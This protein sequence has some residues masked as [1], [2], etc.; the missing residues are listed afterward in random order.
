MIFR[1]F[2]L[3]ALALC[4]WLS[5]GMATAQVEMSVA[6]ARAAGMAQASLA[7]QDAWAVFNNPAAY[8]SLTNV[9]FGLY[10]EN[11]FLLKETGYA[12]LTVTTP[13][14]AGNIGFGV[15]HFGY[16]YFQSDRFSLGYAQTLFR[17]LALGV[18]IDY[19]SIRQAE[20]YGNYNALT[21]DVGILARPTDKLFIGSY[22][23]NPLNISSFEDKDLKLPVSLR[24]GV[25]Y[26]FSDALLLSLETGKTINGHSPLL[27][28][29]I[30][31][32]IRKQFALRA[33]IAAKPVEYSCGFGYNKTFGK[34]HNLKCDLAFA[35]HQILGSSPKISIN[36]AF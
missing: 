29:G 12:A 3:P 26:L 28:C 23:G 5:M 11:R 35:Y 36:Y 14:F 4:L 30:E 31:Y 13:L 34:R 21:F 6:G 33:G 27:C 2:K 8:G 20:D 15:S 9:N 24:L 18:N 25:A 10:Y 32:T 22:I 19:Y 16:R 17:F 1:I 7:N